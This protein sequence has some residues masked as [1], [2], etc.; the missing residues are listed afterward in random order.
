MKGV[1]PLVFFQDMGD[2]GTYQFIID[3][4]STLKALG[5]K[6]VMTDDVDEFLQNPEYKRFILQQERANVVGVDSAIRAHKIKIYEKD[7]ELLT[8][9]KENELKIRG[10]MTLKQAMNTECDA[11]LVP[12]NPES[13]IYAR[14]QELE[15]DGLIIVIGYSMHG[16]QKYLPKN[17]KY[18]MVITDENQCRDG[19]G[20]QL[21]KGNRPLCFPENFE[22]F[23]FSKNKKQEENLLNHLRN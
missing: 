18:V 21:K 13:T 5:Y 12:K 11:G 4:A 2:T 23:D 16:V 17:T 22:I 6:T 8:A 19:L 9:C 14:V 20:Q 7:F 10:A 3:H 1:V 15:K